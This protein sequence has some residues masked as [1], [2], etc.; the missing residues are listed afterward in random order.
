VEVQTRGQ[1]TAARYPLAIHRHCKNFALKKEAASLEK[2]N[3]N[4][5]YM[6]KIG[7]LSTVRT[8]V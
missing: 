3:K 4:A 1:Q 5:V 8:L 2:A 7:S 6:Q